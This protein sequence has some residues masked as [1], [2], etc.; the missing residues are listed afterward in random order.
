MGLEKVSQRGLLHQ[1]HVPGAVTATSII[2]TAA[3]RAKRPPWLLMPELAV[4]EVSAKT[5]PMNVVDVP[6]VAELPTCQKTLQ[7]LPP[8]TMMTDDDVAVV[9]VE[10]NW[11][12]N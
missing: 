7:G 10:P 8:L 2:V 6:S 1:L 12:T 5:L 3:L 9:M 11:K 4:I